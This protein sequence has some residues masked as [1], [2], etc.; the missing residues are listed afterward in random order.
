[1]QKIPLRL[2]SAIIFLMILFS[3]SVVSQNLNNHS[4]GI[5]I[6]EKNSFYWEYNGKQKL[7]LGGSV[8][9]NLFQIPDLVEHLDLLYSAGGNYVRN[10]MS[11]RDSGNVWAFNKQNNGLFD[12]NEW[13]D[14]YWRRFETF[15]EETAK[16]D[17]IV[18]I[19][20]WATFDFYME[21]WDINPF[22]PKNNINYSVRRSKLSEEVDSHPIFTENNFFRSVPSQMSLGPVLWFQ[23]QFVDKMLSYS[24]PYNH[25]LY[26]M[27]NETHVTSDWA[28]YWAKY[29]QNKARLVGKK[30]Y[31]TEMWGPVELNHPY[32]AETIY[33]PEIFNFVEISQNTHESADIHWNN[34]V[35]HIELI[36]QTG[37]SRP[38]NNVK[39]YGI[40]GGPHKTT[41][42]A[43]ENFVKNVLMGCAATRF[44]RPIAGQGLN[45]TA[46]AVIRSMREL[47][48][49]MDFFHT[50]N[51][52][53][54]NIL[55]S[56]QPGEAY[57]RVIPG[58]EYAVYFPD[59]GAVSLDL[60][61]FSSTPEI[62]WLDVL[63]TVWLPS[64]RLEKDEIQ[65]ESPGKGH[66][67][68]LIR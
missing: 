16:R 28:K 51:G 59:G 42:D 38:V 6:S 47:S 49:K 18:Q 3:S 31:T 1:M 43:I 26:C 64:K 53:N 7:L 33:N 39:V 67:V 17:I 21:N 46:Q 36:K 10:T 40:D 20:V 11:S 57:C 62:E 22:N 52:P 50:D 5:R 37:H 65:I 24:F 30:V 66:W 19:E 29:I 8:E 41:R 54:N 48:D 56:R 12:L 68:A 63:N 4:E 32:H 45:E 9:D 14:E 2:I 35:A 60:S 27:D 25:V 13:N 34:G 15:L 58:K 61:Q 44:H 23:Q 55:L